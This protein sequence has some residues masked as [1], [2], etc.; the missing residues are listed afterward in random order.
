MVDVLLS[1]QVLS[2]SHHQGELCRTSLARPLIS[3]EAGSALLLAYPLGLLSCSHGSSASSTVFLSQSSGSTFPSTAACKGLDQFFLF[4]HPT[5]CKKLA[6]LCLHNQGQLH[7]VAQ[8]RCRACI[9]E[10]DSQGR[11]R[12][13]SPPLM[14]LASALSTTEVIVY[15]RGA[16]TPVPPPPHSRVAW[17][18]RALTLGTD[19]PVAPPPRSAFL[20]HP[21]DMQAQLFQ[22][23]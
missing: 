11:G 6:L 3:L 14:P 16:I 9:P 22:V 8:A 19:S 4:S 12:G 2:Q 10:F 20:C 18:S 21:V 15:V 7:Y 17:L 1:L 5:A 13:S 23:L